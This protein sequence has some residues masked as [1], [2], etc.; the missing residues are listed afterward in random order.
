MLSRRTDHVIG[1]AHGPTF[2]PAPRPKQRS[3]APANS[4]R[5]LDSASKV[6]VTAWRASLLKS[7]TFLESDG[8]MMMLAPSRHPTLSDE[9]GVSNGTSAYISGKTPEVGCGIPQ[10]RA[11]IT[12]ERPISADNVDLG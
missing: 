8:P 7:A 12:C 5:H 1:P 2:G 11:S 6:A 4:S 9:I 10:A 3:L